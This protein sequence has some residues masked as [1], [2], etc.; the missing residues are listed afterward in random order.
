MYVYLKS[1]HMY[2]L[3]KHLVDAPPYPEKSATDCL[4]L[5]EQSSINVHWTTPFPKCLPPIRHL[6]FTSF[7]G[8][9]FFSQLQLR[10]HS[11]YT[12]D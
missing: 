9:P 4:Y 10:I 1:V 8:D 5:L 12:P 7:E 3:F 11:K 2:H 6:P